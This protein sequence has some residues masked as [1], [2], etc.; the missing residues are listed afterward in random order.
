MEAFTREEDSSWRLGI[1]ESQVASI[2]AQETSGRC[3]KPRRAPERV[4]ASGTEQPPRGWQAA[5]G[6]RGRGCWS[7][8]A[9]GQGRGGGAARRG[10]GKG[11]TPKAGKGALRGFP[12]LS[13]LRR[14]EESRTAGEQ[15]GAPAQSFQKRGRAGL[16]VPP[17]PRDPKREVPPS[18]PHPNSLPTTPTPSLRVPYRRGA[19]L[20]CGC[21]LLRG[22]RLLRAERRAR[23]LLF[24]P[25]APGAGRAHAPCAW[26]PSP[27]VGGRDAG[28]GNAPGGWRR[29]CALDFCAVQGVPGAPRAPE[30]A[31]ASRAPL[32][33]S[34]LVFYP[35][36]HTDDSSLPQSA[37]AYEPGSRRAAGALC[38]GAF[39]IGED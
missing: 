28:R 5:E 6:R 9:H 20:G 30:V 16:W 34:P 23:R 33:P 15:V 27:E 17:A 13:S 24:P 35:A 8:G 22:H 4:D 38:W 1:A 10:S 11:R 36:S 37:S 2:H 3:K 12:G 14:P 32:C 39:G 31:A 25:P 18:R 19:G 29:A 26:P 21:V 7:P